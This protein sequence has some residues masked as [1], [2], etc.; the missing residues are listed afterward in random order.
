MIFQY[1][2][3]FSTQIPTN[4]LTKNIPWGRAPPSLFVRRRP[5]L[6]FCEKTCVKKKYLGGNLIRVFLLQGLPLRQK[7]PESTTDPFSSSSLIW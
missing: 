4:N 3:L 6:F 5:V 2:N 1:F 7:S